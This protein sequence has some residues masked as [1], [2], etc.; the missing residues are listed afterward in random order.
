MGVC[1]YGRGSSRSS[2]GG[3]LLGAAPRGWGP[4]GHDMAAVTSSRLAPFRPQETLPLEHHPADHLREWAGAGGGGLVV[5]P[6]HTSSPGGLGG[7]GGRCGQA[8]GSQ[9]L[10]PPMVPLALLSPPFSSPADTGHG[11]DDRDN[12]QVRPRDPT[13]TGAGLPPV[14]C[15]A[16]GSNERLLGARELPGP[17]GSGTVGSLP[18]IGAVGGHQHPLARGMPKHG[19]TLA[20][21]PS[22]A[23]IGPM[24]S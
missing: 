22:A 9:E 21:P 24:L 17:L 7:I 19:V 4:G 6:W 15:R 8:G 16:A 23:R 14:P 3:S 5:P 10:L 1:G 11:A 18:G 20:S 13:V 12:R 2:G